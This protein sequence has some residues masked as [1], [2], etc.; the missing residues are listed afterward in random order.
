MYRLTTLGL[1]V[2]VA[3]SLQACGK[4]DVPAPAQAPASA[5]SAPRPDPVKIAWIHA[6][7][8]T[9]AGST[10][11]HD[12]GRKAVEAEFGRDVE[13]TTVENVSEGAQA[14]RVI[15]DLAAKGNKVIFATGAGFSAATSGVA[16]EFP[17]VRFEQAWGLAVADNLRAY[18]ARLFECAYLAGVMAG[19]VTRT[20]T[21][22]FVAST[23]IPAVLQSINA[24]T[25]GAQSVHPRIRT[26]V[27]WVN[28]W[29]DP[30]KES[31]AAQRLITEGA[32]VLLQSTHSTAVLQA[33]EARGKHAFG[34]GADMS[35]LAPNAHL[36]S[37]VTDWSGHYKKAVR[38]VL[39][40]TWTAG[41]TIGGM[42]EGLVDVVKIADIVPVDVRARVDQ[43][44]G[45]LVNGSLAVF[46]GPLRD[47]V[48][49]LRLAP[50]VVA[51]QDGL[52]RLDHYV[53]G[54]EG[55]VP[56]RP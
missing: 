23:P 27:A 51:A 49:A 19:A 47:N 17:D 43:L 52:D 20:R 24:F 31:A 46:A 55:K 25:L 42:K 10:Q 56:A 2:A 40:G 44:R 8:V 30:Q 32:D 16:A 13:S 22:G 3:L 37:C 14:E 41:R 54:V 34:W 28:A 5:A 11:A 12:Q 45:G 18:E 50:G 4:K 1:V 38:D 39:G 7:P 9:D 33:A 15:R 35:A 53:M 29:F 36:A 21:L 6:G 26:K 48:G